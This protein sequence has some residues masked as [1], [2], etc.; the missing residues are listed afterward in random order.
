MK[1]VFLDCGAYDGCSVRHFCEVVNDSYEYEVYSFEVR[2]R[3]FRK[4]QEQAAA[5]AKK[6]RK[7]TP[8]HQGVWISAGRKLIRANHL[9]NFTS[10]SCRSKRAVPTMDF[11]RWILD[12]FD[13]DD[14]IIL[15]MD[16]EG[17]EYAV[18]DKMDKDGSLEYIDEFYGEL[19]GPKR[20]F[21]VQDNNQLLATI[22]R[23]NLELYNWDARSKTNLK[24]FKK[25]Q[26]VPLGAPGSLPYNPL[27]PKKKD[28]T[29]RV[30]HSYKLVKDKK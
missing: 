25:V 18:I 4:L 19:H 28:K 20:G 2:R 26:I 7:F 15:K 14:Y 8:L 9:K 23:A 10:G 1:K 5:F 17:A 16:I 6:V 21:T 24:N 29:R 3:Y 22:A 11:S 13:K 12:N 30:N 27:D